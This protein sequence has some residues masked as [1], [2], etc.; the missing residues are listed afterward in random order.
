MNVLIDIQKNLTLRIEKRE[1]N[2]FALKNKVISENLYGVDVKDWA[3]M[4]GELRLWLS[5]I[6]ETEEKYMDIYTKPLLP[7]LT[8]K[9][10]QGDSL[11]EEI[12]GVP[13][14]LRGKFKYI[15]EMTK[16]RLTEIIDKKTEYFM[17][18]RL[19]K[20]KELEDLE[21]RLFRDIIGNEVKRI[22]D[23]I[24]KLEAQTM[25]SAKQLELIKK[26]VEQKE[27][28]REQAKRIK[29][30][31]ENLRIEKEKFQKV[32]ANIGKKKTK[33]YFL[34]EIDFAEI[35]AK[36]DGFDV[37][38]GNPPYVRQERIAFPL[39][40]VEDYKDAEEWRTRKR[41][42]KEK[43]T[44]SMRM[45]WGDFI[46]INK[47]SDLY[48]YFY[49][50]GLSLLHPDG[51]F[52][53]INSNSWLDVGYGAGLQEFLLKKM[54]PIYIIDNQAKRSFKESDI[55]TVIVAIKRPKEIKDNTVKFINYKKP[56]EEVLTSDN[57]IKIEQS[58]KIKST[59]DFRVFPITK[60]E[61][62]KD[63]VEFPKKETLLK[64]PEHLPYIG[65]KWGGKYLRAPD[66]FFKIL[67][68]GKDKLV[69][70]GDIAEIRRGFTTGANEFFYLEPTGKSA[71]KGLIH[72]RN[73][74]GWEGFL[75][76]EFLKPVI[77]SPREI[78]II[79][80]HPESLRYRIFMCHKSKSGLKGT[81]V[82]K[83]IKWGERKSYHMRPSCYN[84]QLWWDLGIINYIIAYHSTHNPVW[85]IGFNPD[86]VAM[87]KVFYGV[88]SD[89]GE[90]LALL[91][92]S[93]L[94]LFFDEFYGYALVGG[95]GTFI[96]VED[97]SSKVL[98][99]SVSTF[100]RLQHNRL[101]EFFKHITSRE[102]KSIF[103]ELGLPKPNRDYSN[104]DPKDISFDKVMPD[105]RELDKIIF[106]VLGLTEEEQLEV[107]RAVVELV[108]NRLVK[109]R[110][111]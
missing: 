3:V 24:K 15:P 64:E 22:D 72:V 4:V 59:D 108:K 58:S 84:R 111:V 42:Y 27:L 37:V 63:G 76:K 55:N 17:S 56:F 53:F 75:E 69:R 83:Y 12:A 13:L 110:S 99:P 109:A 85:K 43:L 29:N 90:F 52:C 107:Y 14:S 88:Q 93:T 65:N 91:L 39:E 31:V 11:V 86:R 106:E 60:K 105:R 47:K 97:L 1:E 38:I 94:S 92:N 80:V 21:N 18:A 44:N 73:G 104:I 89:D 81:Y 23:E 35:F 61:L 103:E 67:E 7:N 2:L 68:K 25:Q 98:I 96:T 41:L 66:I 78:K 57:L 101:F 28:F 50:A 79:I 8:F 62:L 71:P 82:L 102:I 16:K 10:R 87:D 32:L 51:I 49:Y 77:K 19:D 6:I 26:R 20:Q 95:G 48:V 40:K 36:K 5:L 70:L 33:D 100:A 9:M 46:K 74:A 54:E 30:K 45:N 34:W